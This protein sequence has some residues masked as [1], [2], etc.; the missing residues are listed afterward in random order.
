MGQEDTGCLSG[1]IGSSRAPGHV[2]H[3]DPIRFEGC[4]R[5]MSQ[6]ESINGLVG[7]PQGRS[8]VDS[9][10]VGDHPHIHV[11]RGLT[12]AFFFLITRSS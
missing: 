8:L 10:V 2:V 7:L 3:S 1:V 11:A 12:H 6:S 5:H 9:C 4:Q